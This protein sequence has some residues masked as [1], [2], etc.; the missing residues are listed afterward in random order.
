MGLDIV[1]TVTW[2]LLVNLT[3]LIFRIFNLAA[4]TSFRLGLVNQ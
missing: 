1:I 3:K 4:K 2:F